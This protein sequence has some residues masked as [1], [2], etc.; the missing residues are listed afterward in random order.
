MSTKA[1]SS[2]A[3]TMRST[4][5]MTAQDVAALRSA[6][7]PVEMSEAIRLTSNEAIAGRN[8]NTS[9]AYVPK[10]KLL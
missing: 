10:Q 3:N 6:Q 7:L 4:A 8:D 2:S 9:R 1:A 5:L